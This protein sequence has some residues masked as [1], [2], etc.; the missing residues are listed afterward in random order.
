MLNRKLILALGGIVY[1][2]SVVPAFAQGPCDQIKNAC[3]TAGF[4]PKD[5]KQGRGL[6]RDCVNPIMQGA[7]A[8]ANAVIPVPAVDPGVVA[9]CK[10]KH[11][12][13]G[14]GKL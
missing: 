9:A 12:N 6:W 2:V 8:P 3:L 5:A 4:I 14:E 1:L 10:A 11:P 7:P 13:F